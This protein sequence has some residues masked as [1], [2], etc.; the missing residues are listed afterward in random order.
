VLSLEHAAS[1][2]WEDPTVAPGG[3][4]TLLVWR[5]DLEVFHRT[6][7]EEER[8]LFARL[9]GRTSLQA[10]CEELPGTVEEAAQALFNVL[11]RF[12]ADGVLARG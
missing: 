4:E 1:T 9:D 7:S 2:L 6:L 12:I 10:I 5:Q 11:G 8:T 3:P